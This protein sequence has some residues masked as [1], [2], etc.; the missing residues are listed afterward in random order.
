MVTVEIARDSAGGGVSGRGA[1]KMLR[2]RGH[3]GYAAHGEDIVCAAA[4][5]T[6]FTAAGA[7][8]RLCGAPDS[9]TVERDGYLMIS[10]PAFRDSETAHRADIIMEAAY[11]GFKQIEASYPGNLRVAENC[12]THG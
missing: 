2:V 10:V 11:I 5:A 1:V 12:E 7:L 9:C 3:A 8:E 4:S 6:A